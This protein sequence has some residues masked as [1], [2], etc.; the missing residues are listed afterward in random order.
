MKP[1]SFWYPRRYGAGSWQSFLLAPMSFIVEKITAGKIR[2]A[3]AYISRLP[4][5]CIGNVSVGGTG[6]TPVALAL[7]ALLK[8]AGLT[9]IYI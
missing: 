7:G 5:I 1:P 3:P 6:K 2:R 9:P 8:N 4:V